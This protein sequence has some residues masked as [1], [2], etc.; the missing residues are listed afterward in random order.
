MKS[1]KPKNRR[2]IKTKIISWSFVPT[3]IIL[4]SV[5]LV[6]F[7]SYQKVTEDLVFSQSNVVANYMSDKAR[8]VFAE[9]FNPLLMDFIFNLDADKTLPLLERAE[10]VHLNPRLSY[11]FDGGIVFLDEKGFVVYTEPEL[12]NL[13][14]QDWSDR[15]FFMGAKLGKGSLS[16][17]GRIRDDGPL[18]PVVLPIG[19][20]LMD[21]N[22]QFIGAAVFFVSLKSN[23]DTPFYLAMEAK[24]NDETVIILDADHR[25]LYH[26]DRNYM[27]RNLSD[28]DYLAPIFDFKPD[29]NKENHPASYRSQDGSTVISTSVEPLLLNNYWIVIKEQ[30]WKELMA[31]S[32][33][34]RRL[35]IIL[36]AAG[37]LLPI[38]VV[39]YGVRRLT[40]PIDQMIKAARDIADGHFGQKIDADS[41]DEL[42]DLAVQFNKMS[43][44]LAHS[45]AMLEQRVNDRTREL[46]TINEITKVVNRTLNIEEVLQRALEKTVEITNMDAGNAYR[47]N[48]DSNMMVLLAYTGFSEEY[49]NQYRYLPL[50]AANYRAD[51]KGS[52][53]F[54]EY[55]EAQT[56]PTIRSALKRE[57]V[58]V[59]VRLLLWFKNRPVGLI[60]LAKRTPEL[61]T[62]NEINVFKTIG[63]QIS[64]AIENSILYEQAEETAALAERSR[65][66]REL[67]DAVSQT[68]FSASLIAEV[69]P[70]L[71]E[72]NAEEGRKRTHELRRLARGAL[73]EM[74]TLLMELR[75]AALTQV[76]LAELLKQ[77]CEAAVG[78]AQLPIKLSIEGERSYP[79]DV[80][81]ALYRITQEALNNIIKYAHATE[82]RLE[83]LQTDTFVEIAVRDDGIGF[84]RENVAANHFGLKIMQERA[85]AIGAQ[86]QI[87]STPGSGSHV[88]VTW[89][90]NPDCLEDDDDE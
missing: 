43:A 34:Y 16:A 79:P 15:D 89:C 56:D 49:I 41:G 77:L 84:D 83:L 75:P 8:Q 25:A 69:L 42:E 55:V 53:I 71:Y 10:H 19:I 2:S 81:V 45:Y 27:G 65:L 74:R 4:I 80:Q 38:V 18:Y 20:G 1:N 29:A 57:G 48:P 62:E 24:F 32:L 22:R 36:L 17:M 86:L 7:Y 90:D 63:R 13:I 78:R 58:H 44:E 51:G 12:P 88:T 68:L 11:T 82:V 21:E 39:T 5:A 35:L 85:A 61:L 87:I 14:G 60:G 28:Q 73:A 76:S 52:E 3:I 67:H 6:T 66:A 47:L 70:Q 59:V 72:S 40:Q 64:V 50:A 54:V 37:V 9:L 26:F 46:A 31:P 30:S 23:A 33:A